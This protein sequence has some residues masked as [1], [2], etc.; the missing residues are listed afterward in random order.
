MMT[1][2]CTKW[3]FAGGCFYAEFSVL[4]RNK[5]SLWLRMDNNYFLRTIDF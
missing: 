4:L 3:I 2:S 5:V 1:A